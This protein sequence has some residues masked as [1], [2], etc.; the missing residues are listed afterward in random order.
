MTFF[1]QFKKYLALLHDNTD[2]FFQYP[3]K[4]NDKFD[5]KPI[6]KN[7]LATM[8]KEISEDAGL[9]RIYMNDCIHRTTAT[10]IRRQGFELHETQ[11]VTKHKNLDSLKHDIS[12]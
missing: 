3:S 11:N 4:E 7:T 9:S 6:G 12:G 1:A 8:M 2:V 10:E 5:H